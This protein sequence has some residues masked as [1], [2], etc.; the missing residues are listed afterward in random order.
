MRPRTTDRSLDYFPLIAFALFWFLAAVTGAIQIGDPSLLKLGLVT[1]P[2][3]AA[4]VYCI[5]KIKSSRHQDPL[6]QETP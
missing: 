5:L 2:A 6:D 1:L 4:V 3:V